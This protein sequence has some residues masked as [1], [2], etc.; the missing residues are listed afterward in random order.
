MFTWNTGTSVTQYALW[1]GRASGGYDVYA[2]LE[3]GTTRTVTLPTD[4]GPV[5][6]RLWSYI[7]SAWQ[8]TDYSYQTPI[9]P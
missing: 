7:N 3:T 6:V 5:Y 2:A 4:G 1:I 8:Y 9:L